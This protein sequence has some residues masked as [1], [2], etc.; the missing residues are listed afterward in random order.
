M[1]SGGLST[2]GNCQYSKWQSDSLWH[3][4]ISLREQLQIHCTNV[5]TLFFKYKG[6]NL[7]CYFCFSYR[8]LPAS[9]RQPRPSFFS[10]TELVYDVIPED[11]PGDC[12]WEFSGL[13][14]GGHRGLVGGIVH[15]PTSDSWGANT[16]VRDGGLGKNWRNHP[17]FCVQPTV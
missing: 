16:F 4:S 5:I 7:C 15:G 10:N 1:Q 6:R 2:P 12:F 3:N 17:Q 8:H 9:C 14:F 13:A 11:Q